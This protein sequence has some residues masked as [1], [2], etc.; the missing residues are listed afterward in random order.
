MISFVHVDEFQLANTVGM[1]LL[2]LLE[3]VTMYGAAA[4]LLL[5]VLFTVFEVKSYAYRIWE[6]V[7]QTLKE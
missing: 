4:A 2:I 3:G 1:I 5:K 7:I 6:N